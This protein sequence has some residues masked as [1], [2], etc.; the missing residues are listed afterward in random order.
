MKNL[1]LLLILAIGVFAFQAC[2]SDDE[3]KEGDIEGSWNVTG[4]TF[5]I[6]VNGENLENFFPQD[7]A[8]LYEDLFTSSFEDSFE[9]ATMEFKSDGTYSAKDSDG[10][11]DN[12]SWSINS[13]GTALTFDG[14]TAD[15][16]TFDVKTSTKNSLILNYSE[17]DN[18][19]DLDQDGS[20]DEFTISF[21]LTMSK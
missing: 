5:D 15:E 10:S 17:T 18:S 2:N 4:L 8:N 20:N 12:G 9:G 19:Q 13:D 11:T 14:G 16:I 3:A 21:D 1:K 7:Q 6:T